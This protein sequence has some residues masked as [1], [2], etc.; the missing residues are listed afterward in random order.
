MF[1]NEP[2]TPAQQDPNNPICDAAYTVLSDLEGKE[3]RITYKSGP[4]P[5]TKT[6]TAAGTVIFR[7]FIMRQSL[8]HF[9]FISH[10]HTRSE[11]RR[12]GKECR[13]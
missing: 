13:L 7:S 6:G 2:L 5:Y 4:A 12:V 9:L 1:K 10:I 3:P 8:L 11:E